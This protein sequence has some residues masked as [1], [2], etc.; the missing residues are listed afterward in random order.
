MSSTAVAKAKCGAKTRSGTP[1]KKRAGWGTDH[2]GQGRCKLHGGASPIKHGRYSVIERE[3]IGELTEHFSKDEEPLDIKPELEMVRALLTK[4]INTYDE[5]VDALV[6]WNAAEHT[7]ANPRPQRLPSLDDA[8]KYLKTASKIAQDEKKL[9][10]QNAISRPDLLRVL[11]EMANTV[12]RHVDDP[13]TIDK[14]KD[15]WNSIQLA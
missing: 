9:R 4:Y 12:E 14:I 15:G 11:S 1:C 5:I 10:V 7:K 13:K 2:V 8:I 3:E 6:A